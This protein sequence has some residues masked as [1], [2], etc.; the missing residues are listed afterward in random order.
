MLKKS[1][2]K[3]DKSLNLLLLVFSLILT[4]IVFISSSSYK[5]YSKVNPDISANQSIE[6]NP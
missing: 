2:K 1:V 6:T 5:H 3:E 4:G